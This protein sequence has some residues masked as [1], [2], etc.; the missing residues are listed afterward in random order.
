MSY[1]FNNIYPTIDY[2]ATGD[3]IT[4]R[5]QDIFVRVIA[6]KSVT[7]RNVLFQK[8]TI[9]EE[10]T[11]ESIANDIYG[12]SQYYWV[13]LLTNKIYD[14]YYEWPMTD[15]ILRKYVG[16]KYTN[17]NAAHHY[18]ISQ[19]SGDTNTKIKVELADEPTATPV[20]NYEYEIELND[21]RKDIKILEPSYFT[22]FTHDYLKLIKETTL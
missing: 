4:T 22:I 3:G 13:V 2:D 6:K 15:R 20:T 21:A 8:Y 11:P 14:R 9:H 17:P 7:E 10:E 19:S 16:D 5:I 18:E 1:Y 12:S